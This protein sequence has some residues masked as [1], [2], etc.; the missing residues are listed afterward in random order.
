[1][2]LKSLLF[3]TENYY[4]WNFHYSKTRQGVGMSAILVLPWI[5]PNI[6]SYRIR[7]YPL[8]ML[9]ST[10]FHDSFC[11]SPWVFVPHVSL[12]LFTFGFLPLVAGVQLSCDSCKFL[13]IPAKIPANSY[14]LLWLQESSLVF[15]PICLI[16]IY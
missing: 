8:R 9:F 16:F 14:I 5:V 1:M 11:A 3:F 7:V 4:F 13:R 12:P 2:S 10:L 15:L 6:A